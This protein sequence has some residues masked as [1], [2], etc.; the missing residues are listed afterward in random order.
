MC[1]CVCVFVC[2]VPIQSCLRWEILLKLKK[3]I[4]IFPGAKSYTCTGKGSH[5]FR[6]TKQTFIPTYMH[7]KILSCNKLDNIGGNASKICC[8]PRKDAFWLL[9]L[10]EKVNKFKAYFLA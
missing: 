5:T 2:V 9:D 3:I 8:L 10:Q 7:Q 1:V 4:A 6:V